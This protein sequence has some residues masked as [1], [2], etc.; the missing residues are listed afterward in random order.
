LPL[1]VDSTS[2]QVTGQSSMIAQRRPEKPVFSFLN[3]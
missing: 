1:P 2:F 3:G